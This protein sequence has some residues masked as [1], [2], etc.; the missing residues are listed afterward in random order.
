[1]EMFFLLFFICEM[2][3]APV[4]SS[5]AIACTAKYIELNGFW[6]IHRCFTVTVHDWSVIDL[7]RTPHQ[8]AEGSLKNKK[9]FNFFEVNMFFCFCKDIKKLIAFF[10]DTRF[11]VVLKLYFLIKMDCALD[12]SGSP[13]GCIA[14]ISWLYKAT[15]ELL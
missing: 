3:S 9:V 8:K 10:F 14:I 13:A 1:M 5:A 12:R 4:E 2:T 7:T 6:F 11:L 15:Q